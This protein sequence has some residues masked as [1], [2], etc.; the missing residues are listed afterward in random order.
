MRVSSPSVVQLRDDGT[1]AAAAGI[2]IPHRRRVTLTRIICGVLE[3]NWV[4]K[5]HTLS[6]IRDS[7]QISP[8]FRDNR[9]QIH[10]NRILFKIR[11][12][13]KYYLI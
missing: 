9:R 8:I 7:N 4:H 11:D 2:I 1:T 5:Q 10:I 13:Y 6:I 3:P 12:R